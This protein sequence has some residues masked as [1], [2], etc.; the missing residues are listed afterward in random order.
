MLCENRHAAFSFDGVY[1]DLFGVYKLMLYIDIKVFLGSG[2]DNGMMIKH[3]NR[4]PL[5]L[6]PSSLGI[7]LAELYPLEDFC[8]GGADMLLGVQEQ[9]SQDESMRTCSNYQHIQHLRKTDKQRN[10]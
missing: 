6:G 2:Q 4:S 10:T 5:A 3:T 8:I 9:G 1:W 7:R